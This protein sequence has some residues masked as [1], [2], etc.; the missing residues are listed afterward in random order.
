V[1][2]VSIISST[3]LPFLRLDSLGR[4]VFDEFRFPPGVTESSSLE[5]V[6]EL[7]NGLGEV[8]LILRL[9]LTISSGI[10]TIV[11]SAFK[12]ILFSKAYHKPPNSLLTIRKVLRSACFIKTSSVA[13]ASASSVAYH[14]F[15]LQHYDSF[16]FLSA[17]M[18]VNGFLPVAIASRRQLW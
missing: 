14:S 8:T 7:R 5:F 18:V 11:P 3:M 2:V 13:L 16:S 10:P 15:E 1:L 12:S 9:R 4:D 17:G 6:V